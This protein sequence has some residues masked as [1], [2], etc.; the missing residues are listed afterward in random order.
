MNLEKDADFF[1]CVHDIFCGFAQKKPELINLTFS[2]TTEYPSIN[3]FPEISI[4]MPLPRFKNGLFYFE[5]FA[6]EDTA[7]QRCNLWSL[8]LAS[9]YHLAAH[10]AVSKYNTYEKWMKNKTGEICVSVID[11][12]EDSIVEKYISSTNPQ[13]WKSMSEIHGKLV[14]LEDCASK[15]DNSYKTMVPDA[16]SAMDHDM[17][18]KIKSSIEQI[19]YGIDY[20][21]GVLEIADLLYKN[22]QLL[23]KT[24]LPYRE[25]DDVTNI[26]SPKKNIIKFELDDEFKE[27]ASRLDE[28]WTTEEQARIRLLRQYGKHLKDLHFDYVVVSPENLYEFAQIKAKILPMLQRIRQQIRMIVNLTDSPKTDQIGY[29]DMQMTIQAIASKRHSF[30]VFEQDEDRRAEEAWVILIDKSASM[31]LRFDHIKEFA[32]CIAEAAN[33]LTG[34]PD[35]WAMY[36]FDNNFQILKDFKE[37]YGRQVQ[38]RLGGLQNNGLSLLPDAIELSYRMLIADSREKKYLFV[39]TDGHPSGYERIQEQFSKITRKVGNA[40]V[41]LVAIGV[42]KATSKKFKNSVRG[43]DLKQLVAKF[44]TAYRTAS[45]DM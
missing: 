40:G 24:I 19:E 27:I 9:I 3:R 38:A 15:V 31:R 5:G 18:N 34:K 44:I 14:I 42:S 45:S 28:L 8:Y 33:E 17:L 13:V 32:I 25:H 26:I 35:A 10:A 2:K 16:C 22:R 11:F 23:P 30:E 4:T 1:G 37:R 41:I 43:T 7:E 20:G 21:N 12:I 6:F 29:V 39:I 36:S